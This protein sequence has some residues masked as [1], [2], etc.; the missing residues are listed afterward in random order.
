M[1]YPL[2]QTQNRPELRRTG[3]RRGTD[4]CFSI[5]AMRTAIYSGA[6]ELDLLPS[7]KFFLLLLLVVVLVSST[8]SDDIDFLPRFVG[9]AF[10]SSA[11]LFLTSSKV[12][13]LWTLPLQNLIKN[14]LERIF[15]RA[16][17][18]EQRLVLQ[19]QVHIWADDLLAFRHFVYGL[20]DI[21]DLV[22]RDQPKILRSVDD[23]SKSESA[24]EVN[25]HLTL[26]RKIHG[27][28]PVKSSVRGGCMVGDAITTGTISVR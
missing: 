11:S 5:Y 6:R 24:T 19:R 12:W 4:T 20:Q 14:H 26:T 22:Q 8:N 18:V 2:S 25:S 13:G 3:T 7:F 16:E 21:R 17:D 27:G 15:L 9:P 23:V 10:I 28:L 1:A